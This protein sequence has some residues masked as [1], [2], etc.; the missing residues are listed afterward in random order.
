MADRSGQTEKPTQ[1]RLE[2]ARKEG[3]FPAAREF[4]AAL[5][6]LV[7]LVLL[8]TCGAR[9]FAGFR[10]AARALFAAAFSGEVDVARLSHIA[11]SLFWGQGMPLLMA[12]MGV[13]VATLA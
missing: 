10:Q 4:V 8:A 13:T 1:R 12:G 9:W 7:F 3:Q 11:W 2:K 5:Q 6:F